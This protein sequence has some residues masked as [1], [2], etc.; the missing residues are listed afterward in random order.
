MELRFRLTLFRRLA[1]PSCGLHRIG[2]DTLTGCIVSCQSHLRNSQ[3]TFGCGT[4]PLDGFHQIFCYCLTFCI[5]QAKV[6]TG[7]AIALLAALR[8]QRT[9]FRVI[10]TTLFAQNITSRPRLF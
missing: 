3:S 6:V 4:K 10:L 9:G 7:R 8:N 2:Y 5:T 1:H